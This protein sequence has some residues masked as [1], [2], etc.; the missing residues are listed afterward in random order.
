MERAVSRQISIETRRSQSGMTLMELVV[1]MGV[2][3]F[4]ALSVATMVSTSV[5]LDK[6]AQERS[7]AT[8]LAAERMMQMTSL[9]FQLPANYTQYQLAEETA[10]AGPP[11]TFTTAYGS[12]PEYPE[13]RR[14]VTLNYDTPTAGLLSV[15][16]AVYWTHVGGSEREHRMI[17]FLN[18]SLE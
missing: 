7:V 14:V 9:P 5:H 1:S 16:V 15:E 13:Y 12:I 8:S 4:I 18:P 2:L 11:Q 6:M 10:A 3:S 17:E